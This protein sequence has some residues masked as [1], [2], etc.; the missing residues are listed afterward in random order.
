MKVYQLYSNMQA[1]I[2]LYFLH[3]V[4]VILFTIATIFEHGKAQM[5]AFSIHSFAEHSG[6]V[7]RGPD[8]GSKGC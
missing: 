6:S 3:K 5:L 4:P 1:V 2:T 7:G 8:W